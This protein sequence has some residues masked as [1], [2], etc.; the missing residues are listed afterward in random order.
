MPETRFLPKKELRSTG[1]PRTT[2]AAPPPTTAGSNASSP[3]SAAPGVSRSTHQH[4]M[5]ARNPAAAA[6]ATAPRRAQD[7][8]V[9][10]VDR[11]AGR[12]GGGGPSFTASVQLMDRPPPRGGDP[13]QAPAG[14]PFSMPEALLIA[15]LAEKY[16]DGLMAVS[17]GDPN[18]ATC[19][20]VLD[21]LRRQYSPT[22]RAVGAA[23]TGA[24]P[25]IGAIRPTAVERTA[26]HLMHEH[27]PSAH[28]PVDIVADEAP[29]ALDHTGHEEAGE[30]P[31]RAGV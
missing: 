29:A 5:S 16:R 12:P 1:L 4:V 21:K 15:H 7:A 11:G 18:I 17:P 14:A 31:G 30:A 9:E 19:Q 27:S 23:S 8:R 6:A 22:A 28:A 24:A 3:V 20:S 26:S 13:G 2:S 25:R 10:V